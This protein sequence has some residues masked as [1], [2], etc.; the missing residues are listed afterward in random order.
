MATAPI[1]F[2][3]GLKEQ[4]PKLM[5]PTALHYLS[6]K[7]VKKSDL[8]R[9]ARFLNLSLKEISEL[10][11]VTYRTIQRRQPNQRFGQPVSEQVL[12]ISQVCAKGLDVFDDKKMFLEW[13]NT[14]ILGLGSVPPKSLLS[15]F[16]GCELVM[17]EM[18]RFEHGVYT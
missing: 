16:F 17:R 6:Q 5:D 3:L 10:L 13:L 9:L 15:S 1:S 18:R 4:K 12:A 8:A 2:P 11:P 14:P 7:G